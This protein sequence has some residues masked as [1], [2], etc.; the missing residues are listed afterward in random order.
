MKYLPVK[1]HGERYCNG[2]H[3]YVEDFGTICQVDGSEL[4]WESDNSF[5]VIRRQDCPLLEASQ[6]PLPPPLPIE[7]ICENCAWY[8]YT[9]HDYPCV[10]CVDHNK[11]T[12]GRDL[13]K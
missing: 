8:R 11:F 6:I 12:P 2:C 4:I 10:E 1:L 5:D 9:R 7:I 13:N 3:A